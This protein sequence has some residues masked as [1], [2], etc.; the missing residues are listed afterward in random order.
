[1]LF[2]AVAA[3]LYMA[4]GVDNGSLAQ[5]IRILQNLTL[6]SQIDDNK[7]YRNAVNGI[8]KIAHSWN[9]LLEYFSKNGNMTGFNQ[10]QIN[11]EQ[12]KAR[13]VL[14]DGDF[15]K[16]I[17][18]AEQHHYFGG[19]IRSA[20][21][22]AKDEK[23][24]YDKDRFLSYWEKISALFSDTGPK[25]GHL[26]RQAMLTF[27]DYTLPVG[28]YKTLCVNDPGEAASTPSL[29]RL[30]SNCGD[31]VKRLLDELNL[32][33]D[34]EGQLKIMVK[35]SVVPQSD[36][37]YCFIRFPGLFAW[38]SASHLR[39]REYG[40][41]TF[42]IPNKASN[43]YIYSV[44]LLGLK[45]ILQ[46]ENAASCFDE[47]LGILADHYLSVKAF[48]VHFDRGK[49]AVDDDGGGRIFETETENL[50]DEAAHYLLGL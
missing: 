1:V 21:Y 35:N 34:F 33:G 41:E 47:N 39:L 12:I 6:N 9:E 32:A 28:N 2:H 14:R 25:H 23:E 42:V 5:W 49:I 36:W 11:E 30:F 37:R 10:D 22:L 29:K 13:I 3:Y 8:N 7:S 4:K 40:G 50:L 46:Q 18:N 24:K 43:G 17:Y 45:E 26:L 15:A 48:K 19:Q 16:A 27:G 44:F 31:I 20:L 38:M